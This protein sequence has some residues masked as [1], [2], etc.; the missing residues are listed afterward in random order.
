MTTLSMTPHPSLSPTGERVGVRGKPGLGPYIEI[1]KPRLVFLSLWSV[2]VGFLLASRNPIDF[3]LLLRTL[4]GAALVAAGSMT[5]NQ[6][7]EREVDALMKRTE[8][9]PL[10]SGRMRPETA[11]IFG[12]ALVFSGIFFLAQRVNF[13]SALLATTT[14]ASYLFLYTPLKKK[15]SL[16]T[17]FGAIPGAIPPMIGW[18]AVKGS[19]N[20]GAWILFAILFV[21]QLPHFFAIAWIYREDYGRAG[22][23]MLSVV[24][25]T[26]NQVG[27]QIMIYSLAVH[28]LSFLPP[29]AGVTGNWY[30]LGALLLGIWFIASSFRTAFQL[31]LRSRSFFRHSVLY[32][33]LLLLLMILDKTPV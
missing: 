24:D 2:T 28:L 18:A 22:L 33:A 5:L 6:Y 4:T 11:L 32:L 14:W 16:C 15:T 30:Y 27:R 25:P 12:A 20:A 13:L 7:L 21:W 1:T 19:L 31:D 3:L 17:L 26:G 9:R 10:P 8:K 23:K 29:I